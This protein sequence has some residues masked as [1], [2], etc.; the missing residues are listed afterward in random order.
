MSNSK[1]WKML[2]IIASS[3]FTWWIQSPG[4]YNA[5]SSGLLV[6]QK[7]SGHCTSCLKLAYNSNLF[8]WWM[9]LLT[10]VET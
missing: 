10:F 5:V 6:R 8:V 1:G 9:F 7:T 2:V 4:W 3:F